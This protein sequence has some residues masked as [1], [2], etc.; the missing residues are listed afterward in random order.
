MERREKDKK[1]N[2]QI[3][4]V[5]FIMLSPDTGRDKRKKKK[6][7]RFTLIMRKGDRIVV[8]C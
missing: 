5:V 1:K 7:E 4:P 8:V 2:G 3:I 6:R